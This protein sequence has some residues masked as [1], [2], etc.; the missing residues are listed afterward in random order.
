MPRNWR[1]PIALSGWSAGAYDF[2]ND[3]TPDATLDDTE[4]AAFATRPGFGTTD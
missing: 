4:I 1:L 2:D 3:G